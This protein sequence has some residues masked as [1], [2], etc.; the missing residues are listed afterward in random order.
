MTY[1]QVCSGYSSFVKCIKPVSLHL[2]WLK[3]L[4]IDFWSLLSTGN[5]KSIFPPN[6]FL[7]LST[8]SPALVFQQDMFLNQQGTGIFACWASTGL[9][10]WSVGCSEALRAG[11]FYMVMKSIGPMRAPIRSVWFI[12]RGLLRR[13][14][15][16]QPPNE[17]L[18]LWLL[19]IATLEPLCCLCFRLFLRN[20][21]ASWL[22]WWKKKNWKLSSVWSKK[23]V[24]RSDGAGCETGC[25]LTPD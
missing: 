5:K 9:W 25:R 24:T 19:K 2:E 11:S 23:T 12:V 18:E 17:M 22:F 7:S 3:L 14:V 10:L 6:K 15:A 13:V 20:W 1:T 8:Y 21:P 4:D 16:W